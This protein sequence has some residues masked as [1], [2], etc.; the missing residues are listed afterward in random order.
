MDLVAQVKSKK[1]TKCE[2]IKSI[3]NFYARKDH[4]IPTR[5]SH[6]KEC[7][8]LQ[9]ANKLKNNKVY[10]EKMQKA[11]KEWANK[12]PFRTRF[13][14][15]RANAQN[16]NRRKVIDFKLKFEQVVKLWKKGCYYCCVDIVTET[17]IGLDRINNN[18]G[19]V[20]N[21]VIPCCGDCNKVRNM[22][23][24]VDET[25]VAMKAVMELRNGSTGT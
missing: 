9:H 13:T 18:K 25:R 20:E 11:S 5:V 23:L 2:K 15:N 16:G 6:C 3:D 4:K 8:S 12:N 7:K 22:I 17:G 1:C 14:R 24:T 21:N 19:Y 10:R